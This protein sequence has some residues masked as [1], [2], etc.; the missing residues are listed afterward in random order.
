MNIKMLD[1]LV[2]LSIMGVLVFAAAPL[3]SAQD[4][5]ANGSNGPQYHQRGRG[6]G[7]GRFQRGHRRGHR[8][9]FFQSLPENVQTALTACR[10]NNED[11]RAAKRA[12]AKQVLEDNG[13]EKPE[14]KGRRGG[15]KAF[16]NSLPEDVQTA[17]KACREN[18]QDDRA[19]KRA[20]VKQALDCLLYT[21]DAADD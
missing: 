9:A 2:S 12:C 7:F 15:R 8:R 20:C 13:I 5:D 11:D 4:T 10:E 14:H 6:F 21:S 3:A 19:A 1:R 16:F 17:L 18:D